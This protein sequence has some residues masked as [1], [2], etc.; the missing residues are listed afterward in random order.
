MGYSLYP[1]TTYSEWL[2]A[3]EYFKEYDMTEDDAN[4]LRQG[5]LERDSRIVGL[6]QNQLVSYVNHTMGHKLKKFNR[7]LNF[8]IEVNDFIGILRLLKKLKKD[9]INLTFYKHLEFVRPETRNEFSN[10]ISIELSKYFKD[11]S[12]FFEI[13]G[14]SNRVYLDI[15]YEIKKM[16]ISEIFKVSE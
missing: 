9:F 6:F 10:Q 16:K 11:L 5:K 13:N 15:L 12:L 7:D 1:P 2:K 14:R 4:I 8:M 3:F